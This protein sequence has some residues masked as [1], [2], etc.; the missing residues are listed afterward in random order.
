VVS[1]LLDNSRYTIDHRHPINYLKNRITI[2]GSL[3][4]QCLQLLDFRL[5]GLSL[6]QIKSIWVSRRL[7]AKE[8]SH[9]PQMH[10]RRPQNS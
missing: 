3:Q 10:W 2:L 5:P 9:Y 8:F 4:H 7:E 6:A 1:P